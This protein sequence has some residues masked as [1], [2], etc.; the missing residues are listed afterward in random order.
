MI[1]AIPDLLRTAIAFVVVLGILVFIHE[2]GHY[3]AAR[4]RG[5]FVE[6]FSIGFGQALAI[7]RDAAGTVWKLAWIPL[8]GYVRLHGQQRADDIGADT[9]I[10]LIPGRTFQ[11]KSV[12]SRAII[13][14]G[15]PAANFVLAIVLFAALFATVGRP[16]M[17]PVVNQVQAGSGAA[18]GGI[19][20]GDRIE[21]INNTPIGTFGD[22]QDF[23]TPH[24]DQTVQV[25]VLRNGQ[26]IVL[27]VTIG[28]RQQDDRRIGLLGIEGGEVEYRHIS[29]PA[30]IAGGFTETWRV[31]ADTARGVADIFIA[32]RGAGEIGGPLRIAQLSGQVAALGLANVVSFIAILSVNLGLINLLPIPV[33]DG[34]HLLFLLCEGLRGRPLSARTREYGLRAGLALLG[35]LFVFATWNDLAHLGLFHWFTG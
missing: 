4:W 26:H 17:L 9:D 29:V 5:V 1:H 13:I 34:G 11:E 12:L 6:T 8:G 28:A 14:A 7:W 16:V 33:L 24:A 32:G 19:K 22:L 35:G 23:V 27:P 3:L 18:V 15:G 2:L 31:T 20:P 30:A 21:S 10:P 25:Q